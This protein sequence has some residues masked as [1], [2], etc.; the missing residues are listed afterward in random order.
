MN[1]LIG[2]RYRLDA[3]IARGAIGTVWRGMDVTTGEPVAV[4]LLRAEAGAVPALM[5]GF[6]T[7]AEILAGLDHPSVIRVRD[8]VPVPRGYAIVMDLVRGLDLRRRLQSD[9]PLPAAVA[10]EVVAQVADAL[11]YVHS[12][13]IVHGDVKP[14]NILVPVDGS[15]VRLA[16]FGVARRLDDPAGTTHATPEYVAP[17]VVAGGPPS[18]EAD[19]YALGIVLY[20]LLCGRS[21]FRGGTPA[22][23]LARHASCVAVPPLG[24]PAAIW[25]II[26]DCLNL[27]SRLRPRAAAIAGRLRAA[28]VALDGYPAMAPLSAE[29][30]TWWARSAEQ[31]APMLA[32]GRRVDWVPMPSA[33]VSPA[34]EYARRLV[35]VPVS[36]WG[37]STGSKAAGSAVADVTVVAPV[38]PVVL[39]GPAERPS[40][41]FGDGPLWP[42]TAPVVPPVAPSVPPVE[43][44]P[45]VSTVERRSR[46]G[47]VLLGVVAGAALIA[48]LGGAGSAVALSDNHRPEPRPSTSVGPKPTGQPVP[49]PS[50][51]PT[52]EPTP[53]G[54]PTPSGDPTRADEAT[55]QPTTPQNDGNS[56]G[57]GNGSGN[58]GNGN[59]GN[60]CIGGLCIGDP[61]PTR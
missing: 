18:P 13:R 32:S 5:Q 40:W 43:A 9:G 56:S 45:V 21:P 4:K 2:G 3:E 46:R 16:D 31:T 61:M 23:V 8:L 48:L 29:A 53:T 7:E 14:G 11:E 10:A 17:E 19:V 50:T 60:G 37:D 1:T 58:N 34:A 28:E 35:A 25:P 47:R 41:S 24:M 57:T 54:E 30:V 6:L 36:G 38:A 42:A 49:S 26:D 20:E 33:P 39:H 55:G 59:N 44:P 12:Q 51:S 27:D 52:T 22:E 15:P